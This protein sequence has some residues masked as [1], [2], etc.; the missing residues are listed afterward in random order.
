LSVSVGFNDFVAGAVGRGL[1]YF[2]VVDVVGR[3][4]GGGGG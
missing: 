2:D 1:Q 3:G 4:G